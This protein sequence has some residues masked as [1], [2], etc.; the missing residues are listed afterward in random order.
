MPNFIQ[1]S[2][3]ENCVIEEKRGEYGWCITPHI[4]NI[5]ICINTKYI[6]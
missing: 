4:Y 1:K 6:S 2:D 3:F 5:H